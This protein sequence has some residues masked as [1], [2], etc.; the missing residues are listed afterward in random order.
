M[1]MRPA[2][3]QPHTQK[4]DAKDI[5]NLASFSPKLFWWTCSE[6]IE[7]IEG[8]RVIIGKVAKFNMDVFHFMSAVDAAATVAAAGAVVA[9]VAGTPVTTECGSR[10]GGA[11][12]SAASGDIP[13]PGVLPLAA[14]SAASS[15][16]GRGV[17]SAAAS[18][19]VKAEGDAV[20]A[21]SVAGAGWGERKR[22]QV[23]CFCGGH[24]RVSNRSLH[25]R[26]EL[27]R[28]PIFPVV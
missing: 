22:C 5:V 7:I 15:D 25:F 13:V 18:A 19:H 3:R 16:A 2:L 26:T 28:A 11:A 14:S 21:E 6:V 8:M 24:Y 1:H 12:S 17:A 23:A 10:G 9:T 27:H 20:V 4:I